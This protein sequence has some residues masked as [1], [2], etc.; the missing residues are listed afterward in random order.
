MDLLKRNGIIGIV[1]VFFCLT[2]FLDLKLALWTTLGIP[3]SFCGAFILMPMFG[4]SLN[5][6]SLFA[7]IVSLGIVVDDAIVVGE[8]IFDYR[9][10][11]LSPMQ[12]AIAGSR[13][14]AAP[15]TMAIL[16]TIAA[17]SP[18]LFIDGMLGKFIRV[19]PELSKQKEHSLQSGM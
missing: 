9:Q 2:L 16:T 5:M 19:I 7:F 1:L 18:L 6:I 15:V 13:E 3:I 10:Q 8:N 14:M 12:A 11:G 17:F 4:V